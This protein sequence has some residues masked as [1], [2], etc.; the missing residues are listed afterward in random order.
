[1]RN[2]IYFASDMHLGS[3]VLGCSLEREKRLV[4]WLESIRHDAQALYLMGDVFDF[5]FE[6]KYVVPK[7]YTRFLGK[8]AELSDSGVEIHFFTG[9]HDLWMKD[10]LSEEIGVIIHREPLVTTLGG[11]TFFLAHGDGL[12]DESK[13]FKL[14][15]S[16]FHN[17]F[18]QFLF[19]MI[20]PRQSFAWAYRWARHSRVKELKNPA[21]FKGEQDE[22]L[23]LFAK[24]YLRQHP[25]IDF[26]VFGHRHLLMDM[27]LSKQSR[28]L[29]L[30]DWM[31]YF[32]Y[33]V[34]DGDSM[35]L[36]EDGL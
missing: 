19:S 16:I 24:D 17:P 21:P 26:F 20:H 18:C 28:L 9:N 7:G 13:S 30:G 4:R 3:S 15:R 6:Y 23:I 2:K 36:E 8:L 32:S 22:H 34:Y 29:I 25:E 12:G 1:M 35:L 10:Y 5:W 31:Q 27:M 14:I 11:Q 33:A